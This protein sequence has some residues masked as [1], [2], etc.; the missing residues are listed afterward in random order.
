VAG[1]TSPT[2]TLAS[3][4]ASNSYFAT[5]TAASGMTTNTNTAALTVSGG[6]G[7]GGGGSGSVGGDPHVVGLDGQEFQF[8][9]RVG[10]VYNMYSDNDVQ[11]N[12]RF[13]YLYTSSTRVLDGEWMSSIGIVLA[14]SHSI[15]AS[16][17]SARDNIEPWF[18]LDGRRFSTVESSPPVRARDY[19]RAGVLSTSGVLSTT[20]RNDTIRVTVVLERLVPRPAT[21]YNVPLNERVINRLTVTLENQVQIYV[22][23]VEDGYSDALQKWLVKIPRRWCDFTL[24]LLDG[25]RRPH[26]VLGQTAHLTSSDAQRRRSS[27]AAIEGSAEDYEVVSNELLDVGSRFTRFQPTTK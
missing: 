18:E 16:A 24:T 7:G 9:G 11:I 26:G 12:A 17:G 2:L 25:S 13:D 1:G 3:V 20:I 19:Q 15:V 23:L 5:F 21:E 22:F 14:D 8:V 4:S 10:R 6:G 27:G